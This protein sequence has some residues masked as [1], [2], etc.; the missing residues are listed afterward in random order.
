LTFFAHYDNSFVVLNTFYR[1]FF[2]Q[3]LFTSFTRTV[4]YA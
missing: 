1:Q 2:F 3:M 4:S